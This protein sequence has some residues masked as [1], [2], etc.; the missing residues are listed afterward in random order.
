MDS[1]GICVCQVTVVVYSTRVVC[2]GYLLVKFVSA[3]ICALKHLILHLRPVG[4]HRFTPVQLL[5]WSQG[6]VSRSA[7]PTRAS[8]TRSLV[9]SKPAA[10]SKS[11][12]KTPQAV[13]II[14]VPTHTSGQSIQPAP[15]L[16]SQSFAHPTPSTP[17][18]ATSPFLT[19]SSIS[20]TST[21]FQ[22]VTMNP[23]VPAPPFSTSTTTTTATA[24]RT[25]ARLGSA[26]VVDLLAS[27]TPPAYTPSRAHVWVQPAPTN[28][29]AQASQARH[30]SISNGMMVCC[31]FSPC[32]LKI[33]P[34]CRGRILTTCEQLLFS[35]VLDMNLTTRM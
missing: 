3:Y 20:S 35:I 13:S 19:L 10:I 7:S 33:L 16:T 27:P 25:G 18:M 14:T 32:F 31:L 22:R 5:Q 4:I 29:N 11:S 1:G 15:S 24:T 9:P 21:P 28:S 2:A 6:T 26:A 23:T 34:T 8:P 30:T 12:H 17:A